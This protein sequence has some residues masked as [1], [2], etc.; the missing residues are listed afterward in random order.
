MLWGGFKLCHGGQKWSSGFCWPGDFI[1][2]YAGG[3]NTHSGLVESLHF[4]LAFLGNLLVAALN[5]FDDALHVQVPAVVHL[6]DNRGVT[7]LA[8]QLSSLLQDPSH[9]KSPPCNQC[10]PGTQAR[11]A[12][13]GMVRR[14]RCGE[15][16]PLMPS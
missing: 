14:W 11:L 15:V 8:V 3:M 10:R 4:S 12:K 5:T 1:A 2:I 6:H 7:Q 13:G 9:V 16:L